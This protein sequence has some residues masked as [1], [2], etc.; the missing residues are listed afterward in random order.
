MDIAVSKCFEQGEQNPVEWSE[1]DEKLYKSTLWHIKNSC[2]N[3][4]KNSGEFEVYN[5]FK[6]L[7]DRVQPK[8]EWSGDDEK[9]RNLLIAILNVNHPNGCFKVN[10]IDT[11]DMEAMSKDELVSWLKSLRPQNTW[12]PSDE[13]MEY[14]AKAISW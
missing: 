5:W 4:G 11:T 3:G 9:K 1:E 8:Q 14:L 6:S 12:K 10:P 2:G 13:Q 7:K